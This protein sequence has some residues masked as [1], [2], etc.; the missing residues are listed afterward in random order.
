MIDR[1]NSSTPR[2]DAS[3]SVAFSQNSFSTRPANSSFRSEAT[4]TN[5]NRLVAYP[6]WLDWLLALRTRWLSDPAVLFALNIFL[7]HRLLLSAL[8][9]V[10]APIAP[11][12]PALG[13]S[14]LR[15][16]DPRYWGP[17]F[18]LFGPWQ[19]W[20]TNW[21]IEIAH[22]GYQVGD[23]T[24]NYPP[25]Y[26]LAVGALGRLFFEQYMLAALVIS[27]LAYIVALVYFYKLSLRLFDEETTRR[28]L[29]ILAAFPSGFFLLS[30][31]TESL[32]LALV[33]AAFYYAEEKKW[34]P[35]A[36]LSAL[37]C[38]TRLQGAVLVIPLLV[39][40][41]Q[42]IK[43]QWRKFGREGWLLVCSPALL[44]LYMSYVYF[45]LGDH[46]F[47]NHLSVVWHVK[48]VLPWEAIFG[49]IAGLFNPNY[50]VNLFYNVVDLIL[51]VLFVCMLI[52]WAQKKL[53]F[54]YLL[55]GVLSIAVFLTRQGTDGLVW[56]SMN[57]YLLSIFPVFMLAGTFVPRYLLKF[58]A[59][60]QFIWALL[61]I[62]WMWAG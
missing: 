17:G 48:F 43:F 25:L 15:G 46:N 32:Y 18:F 35:V 7:M 50:A 12:E 10:L 11:M 5:S 27:N 58:S 62:M 6:G 23:G 57:R 41:L 30:G 36:V 28:S 21:Y 54:A 13:N 8:G 56:M 22:Y 9:T 19:R 14:L 1:S 2:D 29:F 31:Y 45:V 59:F 53:P 61:F 34:L 26:P 4:L 16:L 20:D 44:V 42:Q 52:I 49:G 51:L 37:A 39:I 40:Y 47:S 55:Y 33:L 3:G 38:V 24:T 60:I